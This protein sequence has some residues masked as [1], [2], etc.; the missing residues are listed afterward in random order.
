MLKKDKMVRRRELSAFV[1]QDR[2]IE[3]D[4]LAVWCGVT[5]DVDVDEKKKRRS[6]EETKKWIDEK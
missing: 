4:L 6:K 2:F 5:V 1:V 3:C